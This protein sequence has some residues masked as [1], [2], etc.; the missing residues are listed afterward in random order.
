MRTA[1]FVVVTLH[2]VLLGGLLIQGC[3]S[4]DTAME[5]EFDPNALNRSVASAANTASSVA[6]A[7]PAASTPPAVARPLQTQAPQPLS[8]EPTLSS[9]A[10]KE[11]SVAK[12]DS[13]A[14]IAKANQISLKT[15][16]AANPGVE[17]TKLKIG[18][19]LQIPA[20]T[21]T[22]QAYDSAAKVA[23][24]PSSVSAN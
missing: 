5:D 16:M 2:V 9:T 8:S 6:T 15:L 11:Y 22:S 21:Q 4:H 10:T 20:A 19:R 7:L 12:G 23:S 24:I 14:K 3:R 1:V 17:P 18:Q 13:F